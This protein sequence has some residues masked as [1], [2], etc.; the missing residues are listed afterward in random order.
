MFA[1]RF[2]GVYF[3]YAHNPWSI[4][5]RSGYAISRPVLVIVQH[6]SRLTAASALRAY[7]CHRPTGVNRSYRDITYS[8]RGD[9]FWRY[10]ANDDIS[11]I[12]TENRPICFP[13]TR[14]YL[15]ILFFSGNV[16][17]Y[18]NGRMHF[19]HH[20]RQE[21]REQQRDVSIDLVSINQANT[22]SFF[23]FFPTQL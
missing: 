2:R 13:V 3:H 17:V 4:L 15:F 1:N 10:I 22:F 12:P 19:A 14:I 23:L 8:Y 18:R 6:M 16:H 7:L 20:N 21:R 5:E 11:P 9:F